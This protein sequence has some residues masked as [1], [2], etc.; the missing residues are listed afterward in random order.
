MGDKAASPVQCA[1]CRTATLNL[2][3]AT[4]DP[5]AESACTEHG[6]FALVQAEEAVLPWLGKDNTDGPVQP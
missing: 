5:T 6:Q 1:W 4:G 2:R 3:A